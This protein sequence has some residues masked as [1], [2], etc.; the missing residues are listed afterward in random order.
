MTETFTP[1]HLQQED[2]AL[3]QMYKDDQASGITPEDRKAFQE[4]IDAQRTAHQE[5]ATKVEV[6]DSDGTV[7]SVVVRDIG[8]KALD[9]MAVHSESWHTESK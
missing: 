5:A 2:A 8:D 1:D 6:K 3:A 7:E 9:A 4:L